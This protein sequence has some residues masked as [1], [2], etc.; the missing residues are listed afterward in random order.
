MKLTIK[1]LYESDV[2]DTKEIV[3]VFDCQTEEVVYGPG[4]W[5]FLFHTLDS[6]YDKYYD[7]DI[8]YIGIGCDSNSTFLEIYLEE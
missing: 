6:E 2:I 7:R 1:K 4:R 5:E 8:S 3:R